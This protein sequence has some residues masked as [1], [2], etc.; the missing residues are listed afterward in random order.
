MLKTGTFAVGHE[1]HSESSVTQSVITGN[2]DVQSGS[3]TGHYS[4]DLAGANGHLDN[5]FDAKKL[6]TTLQIQTAGQTLAE[7]AVEIGAAAYD[8]YQADQASAAVHKSIADTK[9]AQA[10]SA[11]AAKRG[12]DGN[13]NTSSGNAGSSLSGDQTLTGEH[14]YAHGLASYDLTDPDQSGT[15]TDGQKISAYSDNHGN[16]TLTVTAPRHHMAPGLD[17][18]Y[19]ITASEVGNA[20]LT[21]GSNLPTILGAGFGTGLAAKQYMDGDKK[22]AALT[23][24]FAGATVIDG[25]NP[26]VLLA[27]S[28]L[29]KMREA[30]R[31]E[32]EGGGETSG[33]RK[34]D[35]DDR[36]EENPPP[37]DEN[38]VP[39]PNNEGKPSY[40][41]PRNERDLRGGP[42]ENAIK[43]RGDVPTEGGPK[44]GTVY[45]ADNQG[46]IT[47][48]ATY[49]KD[50]IILKRVDVRGR[51]HA[52][53]E[54]PH[55]LEYGRNTLP[56]G[57]IKA[58]KP[59][60]SKPREARVDEIP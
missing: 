57:S 27:L 46:N 1:D 4:T 59:K 13:A 48:Y 43:W 40:P 53:V 49:D 30:T 55:V 45:R 36:D 3:T 7:S 11:V 19:G 20:L 15:R 9:A 10:N 26:K 25:F 12:Q 51:A 16:D 34:P 38:D 22:E 28:R 47:V 42:L 50:G 32:G 21:G 33:E 2:I 60:G 37:D 56:D 17:F 41:E 31:D 18:R 14:Y 8:K 24:G 58:Q 52:G 5:D 54:T 39:P 35:T 29:R 6:N 23:L 44:N